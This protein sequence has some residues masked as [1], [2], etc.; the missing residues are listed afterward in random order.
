MEMLETSDTVGMKCAECY[1]RIERQL[2][3]SCTLQRGLQLYSYVQMCTRPEG[4]LREPVSVEIVH[5]QC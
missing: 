1:E 3:H 4:R 2:V 5:G